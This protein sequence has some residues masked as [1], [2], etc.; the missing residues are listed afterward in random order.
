MACLETV[1]IVV[2][3]GSQ[4]CGASEAYLACAAGQETVA[5]E[6]EMKATG[7][8]AMSLP[9]HLAGSSIEVTEALAIEAS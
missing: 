8:A 4:A 5:F 1:E 9:A 7:L 2:V 6:K 3:M